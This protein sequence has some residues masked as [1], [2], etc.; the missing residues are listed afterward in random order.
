MNCKNFWEFQE[1]QIALIEF[2]SSDMS[3]HFTF[4]SRREEPLGSLSEGGKD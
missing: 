3:S 2:L 4:L 1:G